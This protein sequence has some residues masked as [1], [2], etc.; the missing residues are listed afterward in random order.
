MSP[1]RI[2]RSFWTWLV[3]AGLF[4][5]AVV[6]AHPAQNTYATR[7]AHLETVVKCPS[8]EDLSVAQ[9]N[10]E[11]S[12]A[13]RAEIARLVRQGESD[14]QVLATLEAQYGSTILLAPGISGL[15][16]LL[17]TVPLVVLVSGVIIYARLARKK[18]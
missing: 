17:I 3:V 18:T 6:I 11:S 7:I 5:A 1:Q 12:V 16:I 14:N 8:C 15:T 10:S 4:F 2:L 13:I 9:S